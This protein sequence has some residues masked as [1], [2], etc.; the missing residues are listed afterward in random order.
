M[1]TGMEN[2]NAKQV[3]R[4]REYRGQHQKTFED[5]LAEA[6]EIV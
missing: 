1:P 5:V 2:T 3:S 6:D 4:H